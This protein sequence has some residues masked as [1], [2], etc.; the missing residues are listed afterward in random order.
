M[1]CLRFHLPGT[2]SNGPGPS[3]SVSDYVKFEPF[4]ILHSFGNFFSGVHVDLGQQLRFFSCVFAVLRAI[5]RTHL[6]DHRLQVLKPC[7]PY[8]HIGLVPLL[9]FVPRT[10]CGRLEQERF[11]QESHKTM[12]SASLALPALDSCP[13]LGI[14]RFILLLGATSPALSSVISSSSLA[15]HK[16]FLFH[17]CLCSAVGEELSQ[18]WGPGFGWIPSSITCCFGFGLFVPSVTLGALPAASAPVSLPSPLHLGGTRFALSRDF[19]RS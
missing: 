4:L 11:K 19:P 5:P 10:Q 2:I 7:V 1:A 3:G 13:T 6:L 15:S 8:S 16:L 9:D 17:R 14:S 18:A 12:R